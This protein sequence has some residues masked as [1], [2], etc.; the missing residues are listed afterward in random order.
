MRLSA[1]RTMVKA[2][3]PTLAISFIQETLA[4]DSLEECVE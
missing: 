3:R 2:Y 1:L 4:F